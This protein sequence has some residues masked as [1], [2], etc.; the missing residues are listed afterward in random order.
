MFDIY[1]K[2]LFDIYE[3]IMNLWF[4]NTTKY[5][6]LEEFEMSKI[7]AKFNDSIAQQISWLPLINKSNFFSCKY[8]FK[9][10]DE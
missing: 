5:K 4:F 8:N 9:T 1:I 10:N 7:S 3:K 2:K 6:K